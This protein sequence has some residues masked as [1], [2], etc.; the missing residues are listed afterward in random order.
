LPRITPKSFAVSSHEAPDLAAARHAEVEKQSAK[1]VVLSRPDTRP[2]A[3][4]QPVEGRAHELRRRRL[5]EEHL[6]HVRISHHAYDAGRRFLD[7][8]RL[9]D[10]P[11]RES[12]RRRVERD[13]D[14]FLQHGVGPLAT[15][16][17]SVRRLQLLGVT[18]TVFVARVVRIPLREELAVD[19][20]ATLNRVDELRDR[21]LAS[22]PRDAIV[23]LGRCFHPPIQRPGGG[24]RAGRSYVWSLLPALPLRPRAVERRHFRRRARVPAGTKLAGECLDRCPATGFRGEPQS[25][26]ER[27]LHG[28]ALGAQRLGHWWATVLFRVV[29]RV[30]FFEKGALV[31][32]LGASVL[33]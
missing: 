15:Q 12:A 16:E 18:R 21:Q 32:A 1:R 9:G 25:V 31:L 26:R 28:V 24:N 14:G 2:G 33:I 5:R 29:S 19:A 10:H 17:R 6:G 20:R 30:G 27:R 22:L 4:I 23:R 8:L 3:P 7:C 13:D 11:L